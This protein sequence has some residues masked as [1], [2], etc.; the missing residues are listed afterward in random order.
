MQVAST[1]TQGEKW[2]GAG[3]RLLRNPSQANTS[4]V[5]DQTGPDLLT[6]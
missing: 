3:V 1:K 4:T 2:E 5:A 6:L